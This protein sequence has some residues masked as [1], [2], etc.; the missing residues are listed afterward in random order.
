[1]IVSYKYFRMKRLLRSTLIFLVSV[2]PVSF[3]LCLAQPITFSFTGTPQTYMVPAGVNFL[4]MDVI[5]ATGGSS[6]FSKGGYGGRVQCRLQVT[7]G[8]LLNIYVGGAGSRSTVTGASGGYNGGGAGSATAGGGGGAS[9]IR[10]D[11]SLSANRVIVAGGG[12]GAS[13]NSLCNNCD[14]GGNG[15]SLAAENGYYLSANSID[16]GGAGG[17]TTVADP[18]ACAAGKGCGKP[19]NKGDGYDDEGSFGG[20]GAGFVGGN[21]GG[22]GPYGGGGGGGSSYCN[23]A[24]CNSVI[25][26]R[27]YNKEG[28]GQVIITPVVEVVTAQK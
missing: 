18:I 11:G 6:E 16:H 21:G 9:E 27:G 12:G 22:T 7:P 24:L 14:R 26:T 28:N 1:M 19:G 15:G 13:A 3:S 8:E 10:A 20:G 2:S 23:P 17:I 25:H 4:E 5:G